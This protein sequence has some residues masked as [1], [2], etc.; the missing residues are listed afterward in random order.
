MNVK[1]T[2][3]EKN[4]VGVEETEAIQNTPQT[5]LEKMTAERNEYLAGW[6]RAKADFVN[7][8]KRME[9]TMREYRIMANEGLIEE[10]LAVLQSFEMAFANKDAWEKA[11]KNW[12][13]GV[14]HI[15]NQLKS[16]LEQNGLKEISP[17]GQKFDSNIHEAIRF[18]KAAPTQAG[19]V[20]EVMEKGY[21]LGN[22]LVKPA[23]VVVAEN[24]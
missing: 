8:K 16:I 23:K 18:E 17:I 2:K 7:A 24:Q 13:A 21:T 15:Y 6:Q 19:S 4:Q 5:E 11:D 10:L 20:L 14:E 9:K 22:K 12:R 3:N 1:E